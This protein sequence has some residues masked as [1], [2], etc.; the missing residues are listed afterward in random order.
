MIGLKLA[1]LATILAVC[2]YVGRHRWPAGRL[3]ARI[4]VAGN[5]A[6]VGLGCAAIAIYAITVLQG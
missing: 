5:T 4:A 1:T 2:E 3:L 6:A